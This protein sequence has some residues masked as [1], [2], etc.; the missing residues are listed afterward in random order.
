MLSEQYGVERRIEMLTPRSRQAFLLQ[1]VE[2][3]TLREVAQILEISVEEAAA[4]VDQAGREIAEQ[5]ATSVL[6]IE[7]E[8]VIALDIESMVQEL[9]HDVIGVAR[10]RAAGDL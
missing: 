9:G 4:L 2:G 7:D 6:I 10:A 8:P 1:A 3:F 5:V